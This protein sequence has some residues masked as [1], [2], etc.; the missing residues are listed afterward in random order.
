MDKYVS[1]IG[2]KFEES[3]NPISIPGNT[4]LCMIT[5]ENQVFKK[6]TEL[7][8]LFRTF[9]VLDHFI[10]LPES[11]YHMTLLDGIIPKFSDRRWTSEFSSDAHLVEVD[12]HFDYVLKMSGKLI[13]L[14]M[15]CVSVA[16]DSD[17]IKLML[18]PDSNDEKQR[19]R[20]YRESLAKKCGLDADPDYRFHVSL[21][22]GWKKLS[23]EERKEFEDA[24]EVANQYVKSNLDSIT[25]TEV[26][27][28]YFDDMF[29]FRTERVDRIV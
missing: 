26:E 16:Y 6:L 28:T 29:E 19:I 17:A 13:D 3:G 12:K 5:K 10:E 11:S 2:E 20:E 4:F 1:V 14:N 18:E 9:K 7:M 8:D 27:L 25:L 15:S 24:L 22:Y 23:E 21:A